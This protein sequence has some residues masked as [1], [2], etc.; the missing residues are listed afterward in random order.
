MA[1]VAFDASDEEAV[2]EL[3]LCGI[4][5][6]VF[7]DPTTLTCCGKSFC[8]GCLRQWVRTS[9]HSAGIPRCPG[10]CT[11][12]I[13]YRLPARSHTLRS[14]VEQLVPNELARRVREDQEDYD[15]A[16][17]H[18]H[19][20]FRAWQEVAANRDIIFGTK[21][22]VKQ[23]AP[24]IIVGNFSDGCHVTVRF[25]EREDGSELCV[26]VLP[27]ALMAP[28]PGAFRLGQRVI[29]LYE[30]MLNDEIG[31]R[32]GTG[33]VVV[34]S[35]GED[36]LMI[37]FDARVDSG[38][39]S[40]GPVSVGFR[41]VTIQRTLVG[42]FN[43]AQRVQSAMD[44]IVGSQVVVKAGTCG[45]VL[46]EFSDTRLTVAFDTQEGSGSCFNVLPL[47]IKQWCEPRSGLSIG[48]RVQATQDLIGMH[49]VVLKVGTKGVVLGGIDE[50]QVFVAFED[51]A[52]A[53]ALTVEYS[54]VAKAGEPSAAAVEV[55]TPLEEE[56]E[57][58]EPPQVEAMVSLQ[59]EPEESPQLK[60]K[61]PPQ[62]LPEG[63]PE[64]S[65][66]IA[67]Q[68]AADECECKDGSLA[69]SDA[70][71]IMDGST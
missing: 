63:P 16:Q 22:G 30:L 9:V 1:P 68:P 48:S 14:A 42:G 59:P 3:F 60:H 41:E 46:A 18:C 66:T 47:E 45:S 40:V 27:E 21:L 8:R 17:D 71:Q 49:S 32:L 65:S 43:I 55:P 52:S 2:A 64:G 28:L 58:A 61:A 50:T 13:P 26:N 37:L 6:D 36:R 51:G 7:L 56:P 23:G 29:A 25:D 15:A 34:G 69:P 4:C 33:G 53:Q 38:K 31:V 67:P 12:K 44:L 39:G 10:G 11:A 24:G 62:S 57:L 19:G 70:P 35:L 20:G 54:A 5:D